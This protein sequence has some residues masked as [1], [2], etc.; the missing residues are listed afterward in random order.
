MYSTGGAE[1][2]NCVL[3]GQSGYQML[4]GVRWQPSRARL[5]MGGFWVWKTHFLCS[6]VVC[7]PSAP[8][9]SAHSGIV[10]FLL[11]LSLFLAAQNVGSQSLLL[12][13][14]LRQC[15]P[16]PRLLS[17]KLFLLLLHP[18]FLFVGI[19]HAPTQAVMAAWVSDRRRGLKSGHGG[20][21]W[22]RRLFL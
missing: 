12:S 10:Y 19:G 3:C 9:T 21:F 11:Q 8:N 17:S 6:T 15:F 14:Q 7:V 13:R 2:T 4:K 18:P 20:S 22:V 16:S 1:N 5:G